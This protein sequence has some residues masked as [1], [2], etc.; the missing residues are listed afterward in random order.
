MPIDMHERYEDE[1]VSSMEDSKSEIEDD[2][3]VEDHKALNNFLKA[4]KIQEFEKQVEIKSVTAGSYLEEEQAA[5]IYLNKDQKIMLGTIK[6]LIRGHSKTKLKWD[7]AIMVMAVYNCFAIPYQVAFEPSFMDEIYVR[8]INS[9]IDICFM[10]DVVVTFRTTY[11]HQKTGNEIILPRIIAFEY[12]KG[13][14]LLDFLASFPFDLIGELIFG[15]GSASM[16]SLF[17]L[18]KLVRVLRLNR[19]ITVMKVE[20]E[21]K[22]SL[23]LFKLIFF[24]VMFLHCQA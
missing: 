3:N 23:K 14:F 6:C 24:L 1:A 12:L 18:L 5:D 13:R 20:D 19:L 9:L 7:L 15:S 10:I 8:I 22:L 16:L 11:I 17:S 21:V 2:Q 4:Y